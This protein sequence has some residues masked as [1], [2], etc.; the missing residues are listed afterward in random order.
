[1]VKSAWQV[2]IILI[3]FACT[4]FTVLLIKPYI[5]GWLFHGGHPAWFSILYWVLIF[6]IYNLFL[7]FYGFIFGQFHFF[8]DFEKRFFKRLFGKKKGEPR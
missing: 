3:V 5:T 8:W 2:I 6:P 7:L 1:M 4:G